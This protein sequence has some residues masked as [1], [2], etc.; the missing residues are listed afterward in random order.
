M[1]Y[2]VI[3]I[4]AGQAAAQC[5]IKTRDKGYTKSILIIGDEAYLPYQRP[6]LSKKY[7]NGQL[8]D[9]DILIYPK[10]LYRDKKIEFKSS[11]HVQNINA[12]E[13]YILCENGEK[14]YFEKLVIATG[15]RP[16]ALPIDVL[17]QLKNV[18]QFRNIDDCKQIQTQ[19]NADKNL[20]ILGGG[21]I[22]LELAAVAKGFGLNVY[23]IEKSERILQRVASKETSEFIKSVHLKHG[24]NI[25]ENS[26]IKKFKYQE[27][28]LTSVVLNNDQEIA[29]DLMVIGI[30]VRA[31]HE[32]ISKIGGRIEKNAI[33]VDSNCKT[34]LDNIY[35]IG[36][37]TSFDFN[38]EILRLESIQNANEQAETVAN[39]LNDISS[40]YNPIPWFWSDQYNLKLQ[41][42]G[43]GMDYNRVL[44]RI[45]QETQIASFWYLKDDVLK[46][47]DAVNDPRSFMIAKKYL[48]QK[49]KGPDL[50]SNV[51]VNVIDLFA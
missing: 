20:I 25:L 23:V 45:N 3:I 12:K 29:A 38:G 32:L 17:P 26:E 1:E 11:S 35:A 51:D 18:F 37:C 30:G 4:G 16:N 13:H 33:F 46:A 34:S 6:P 8:D 21:Y 40:V 36:D 15:S 50:I 31:N 19:L 48:G 24:V 47:V 22:G 44:S 10:S 39:Q 27:Q 2:G 9:Q 5:A 49:V 7:L 41:I 43:L 14:Y 28:Y 42:A